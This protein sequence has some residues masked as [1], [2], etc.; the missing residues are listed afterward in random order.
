MSRSKFVVYQEVGECAEAEDSVSVCSAILLQDSR[1][2]RLQVYTSL[3]AISNI[4]TGS[5]I[6]EFSFGAP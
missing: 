3:V 1:K 6:L 4:E 5:P 2:L